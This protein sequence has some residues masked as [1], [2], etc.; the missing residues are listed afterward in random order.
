MESFEY[1]STGLRMK[2]IQR[3]EMKPCLGH[4]MMGLKIISAQP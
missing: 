4:S 2:A 3:S 1:H